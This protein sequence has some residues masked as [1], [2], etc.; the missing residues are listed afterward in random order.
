MDKTLHGGE[1]SSAKEAKINREDLVQI[2]ATKEG[3]LFSRS[4]YGFEFSCPFKF[5]PM[6]LDP[7]EWQR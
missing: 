2:V 3:G 1:E 7:L 5:V 4:N 6:L